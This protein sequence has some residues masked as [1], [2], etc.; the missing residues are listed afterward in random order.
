MKILGIDPGMAI[1]GYGII[2]FTK[3]D[4]INIENMILKYKNEI[5][6]SMLHKNKKKLL[7]NTACLICHISKF[8]R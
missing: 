4:I 7:L 6:K 5:K 8:I 1:V 3:D 2:E